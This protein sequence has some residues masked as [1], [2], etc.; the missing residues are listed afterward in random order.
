MGAVTT[1]HCRKLVAPQFAAVEALEAPKTT[2]QC[3]DVAA[4]QLATVEALKPP[5]RRSRCARLWGARTAATRKN[6]RRETWFSIAEREDR[7]GDPHA[8]T[9]ADP[10]PKE[11]SI[12]VTLREDEDG[13][14]LSSGNRSRQRRRCGQWIQLH[15]SKA[16]WMRALLRLPEYFRVTRI[17]LFGLAF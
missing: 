2:V 5:S 15:F 10:L 17:D 8:I 11:V 9:R 14:G 3:L 7:C 13:G 1:V 16:W 6:R 4:P 12:H